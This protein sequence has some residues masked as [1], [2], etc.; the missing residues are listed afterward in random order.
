[1]R[2]AHREVLQRL[3]RV[4]EVILGHTLAGL[5]KL[6]C[7]NSPPMSGDCSGVSWKGKENFQNMAL[8]ATLKLVALKKKPLQYRLLTMPRL[9]TTRPS[10]RVLSCF[11]TIEIPP[12]PKLTARHLV[13]LSVRMLRRIFARTHTPFCVLDMHTDGVFAGAQLR[14][15]SVSERVHL[16]PLYSA[17]E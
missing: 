13:H 17:C 6:R 3:F 15:R 10:V 14:A 16:L 1:M 4:Q 12:L 9:L 5:L 8:S 2:S 11:T 7:G